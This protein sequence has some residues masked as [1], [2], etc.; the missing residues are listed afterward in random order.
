MNWDRLTWEEICTSKFFK[1]L[2][3][4]GLKNMVVLPIKLVL[5]DGPKFVI[6]STLIKPFRLTAKR[7]DNLIEIIQEIWGFTMIICMVAGVLV[8]M[9]SD[10]YKQYRS[11]Y[12][13][14]AE[15]TV[16]TV[17]DI[18]TAPTKKTL[19]MVVANSP[20]TM[21]LLDDIG[22]L[23]MSQA[24]RAGVYLYNSSVYMI[25]QL[26]ATIINRMFTSWKPW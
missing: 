19:E 12:H 11:F 10:D 15:N 2:I 8:V 23:L 9:T 7:C 17:V 20:V 6:T 3:I 22:K 18:V 4:N 13:D 1:D 16:V 26:Y 14:Y 5:W 21:K 24:N 25:E